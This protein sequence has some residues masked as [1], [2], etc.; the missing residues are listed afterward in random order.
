[1]RSVTRFLANYGLLFSGFFFGLWMYGDSLIYPE[2]PLAEYG[3]NYPGELKFN[4][5]LGMIELGVLY[6]ILNPG[7]KKFL[8]VRI[9]LA[10]IL[11]WLW[12]ILFTFL[13]I[14]SG[15]ISMIH[16]IWLITIAIVLPIA[17]IF[18]F[19]RKT[20]APQLN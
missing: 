14:H 11:V 7:Q 10:I 17:F 16:E 1:M 19:S 13:T 6:F 5:I 3:Q 8:T 18:E 2:N 9:L 4:L 12:T 15:N 20:I